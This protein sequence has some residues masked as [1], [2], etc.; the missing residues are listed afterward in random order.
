MHPFLFFLLYA[1]LVFGWPSFLVYRRTGMNPLVFPARD[2][3]FG[4]VGRALKLVFAGLMLFLLA[5]LAGPASLRNATAIPLPAAE[6]MALAGWILLWIS[7]VWL[8]I[9]QWQ[10]G[11]A[12]RIGIDEV[13]PAGLVSGGLFSVSR[14]PVFLGM[15]VTMLGL[16]L[17]IPDA[18]SLCAG[19]AAEIL[20]Q[21]QVRLEEAHLSAFHSEEYRSYQSR[22]RRW[23]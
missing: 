15:R 16:F 2:D 18:I 11:N 14:N 19:I 17:V 6:G 8:L 21:I 23:L 5:Q 13:H 9:A 22:V 1:G 10:M 7:L 4:Y 20:M 12:W 3:A